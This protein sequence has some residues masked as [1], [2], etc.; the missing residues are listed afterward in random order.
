MLSTPY[1][2]MQSQIT[3]PFLP[4]L[5]NTAINCLLKH[6]PLPVPQRKQPHENNGISDRKQAPQNQCHHATGT[7]PTP[8]P[9][10]AGSAL[11]KPLFRRSRQSLQCLSDNTRCLSRNRIKRRKGRSAGAA[12]VGVAHIGDR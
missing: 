11:R 3:Y 12:W 7:T 6:R 9:P 4:T 8:R 10:N 5:P 1:E 2:L